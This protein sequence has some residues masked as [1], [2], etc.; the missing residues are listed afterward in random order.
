[1]NTYSAKLFSATFVSL[2]L[3]GLS[4]NFAFGQEQEND[5]VLVGVS[6][7]ADQINQAVTT[8]GDAALPNCGAQGVLPD[9]PGTQPGKKDKLIHVSY[10]IWVAGDTKTPGLISPDDQ[11]KL[12]I[13]KQPLKD[14]LQKYGIS[15][16]KKNDFIFNVTVSTSLIP[17]AVAGMTQSA[18]IS[19]VKSD[20]AQQQGQAEQQY[21]QVIATQ[22][23]QQAIAQI[24]QDVTQAFTQQVNQDV[25]QAVTQNVTQGV[26]QAV[27]QAVT[28][29]VTQALGAD[30]NFSQL[31]AAAQQ[32][33]IQQ[34]VAQQMQSAQ[35]QQEIQQQTATQMQSAPVQQIIQ[36]QVQTAITQQLPGVIQQ[37]VQAAMPQINQEI[38]SITQ[39]TNAQIQ[40]AVAQAV[41]QEIKTI[42]TRVK[43]S[44]RDSEFQEMF[45]VAGTRLGANLITIQ[46]G[47]Y[48]PET[49]PTLDGNE[50]SYQ[51]NLRDRNSLAERINGTSDTRAVTLNAVHGFSDGVQAS[52][53]A[54]AFQYRIPNISKSSYS[55]NLLA[56]TDLAYQQQKSKLFAHL[57][58]K[59]IR[60]DLQSKH[61]DVFAMLGKERG[62]TV[63]SA[64]GNLKVKQD[65][66]TVSYEKGPGFGNYTDDT[67]A[68]GNSK[69][70][71]VLDDY[72]LFHGKLNTY[73][74]Y[75]HVDGALSA[76]VSSAGDSRLSHLQDEYVGARYRIIGNKPDSNKTWDVGVEYKKTSSSDLDK[77]NQGAGVG[78]S[79][80]FSWGH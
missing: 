27:D 2:S 5:P 65:T 74:G 51:E 39:S 49:G 40:A 60:A 67:A 21:D 55:G 56:M 66:L 48:T 28:Q 59:M 23:P 53:S 31:S 30:P 38:T 25:T 57:D 34:Q 78:F 69:A 50:K 6:S 45:V 12:T 7:S 4:T 1:M 62:Q 29:E 43:N 13:G 64:G 70:V 14:T 18:A 58:S 73:A 52:V 77:D 15:G 46:A 44:T 42:Q 63:Y 54:T 8:M 76:D 80:G 19:T 32:Q 35:V 10:R 11:L 16:F 41:Q 71:S 72:S 68:A 61:W 22:V 26:D 37:Q 24:T 75:D 17:K 3:F 33:V 36:Q 9:D 79:T 20:A 47:K